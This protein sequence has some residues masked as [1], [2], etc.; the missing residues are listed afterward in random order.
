[1]SQSADLAI[2]AG[3]SRT[4]VVWLKMNSITLASLALFGSIVFPSIALSQT[5]PNAF[6][7]RAGQA[8][9]AGSEGYSQSF[10]GRR[11]FI[12]RPEWLNQIKH[13]RSTGVQQSR[14]ALLVRANRALSQAP[15]SVTSKTKTPQSGDK[16]DYYSMGPYWWPDASKPN[17][18]PYIRRDGAVNPER[19]GDGFDSNRMS[20][21]SDSISD[22]ALAHFY[23]GDIRYAEKAAQFLRVWFLDADTKMNPSLTYAQAIP[24]VS[25]GRGEGIID[26]HRFMPIVESI[27][28]LA[29]TGVFSAAEMRDLEIWFGDLA[30]WMATSPNG[31]TERAKSNNHG[32][33]F[34][35]LITHFSLFARNPSIATEV[36]RAFPDVRMTTQFSVDGGLPE[37]LTRTRSWHYSHWTLGA[38]GKLA[39]LGECLG[40]DLWRTTLPDGRGLAKSLSFMANYVARENQWSFPES[41]FLPGGDVTKAREVAMETFWIASWGFHDPSYSA[42]G[43]YYGNLVP[44]SDSKVWLSPDKSKLD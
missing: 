2:P 42:L 22:L 31:R 11:T 37:E 40:L 18:E 13:D 1:M 4:D 41:A 26:S 14:R 33:F 17:G 24:G 19:N 8:K 25:A 38:I 30:I 7:G 35:L 27:G 44:N 9:C 3:S 23:T 15:M 29:P 28:L 12:W 32:V 6:V 5:L 36:V 43:S 20:K 39:G 34:D 10:Q 21:F 16:H